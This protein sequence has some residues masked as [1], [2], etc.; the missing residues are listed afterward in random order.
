MLAWN[1][2]NFTQ[3][4]V[5][6]T[7]LDIWIDLAGYG[8]SSQCL[9]ASTLCSYHNKQLGPLH[10]IYVARGYIILIIMLV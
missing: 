5:P 4:L 10:S 8:Q 1:S 6:D 9:V 3:E 2:D 7:D